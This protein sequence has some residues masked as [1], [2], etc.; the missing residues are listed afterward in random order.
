MERKSIGQF[1]AALRKTNGMTQKQLADLLAVSDKAISRWERDETAPDITLIPVLA[2]IFGVTSD[3]ILRG[4]RINNNNYNFEDNTGKAEK[5]L[6]NLLNTARTKFHIKNIISLGFAVVGLICAMIFNFGFNRARVGF[7]VGSIFFLVAILLEA[8]F[9]ISAFSASAGDDFESES[10]NDFKKAIIKSLRNTLSVIICVFAFTLPLIYLVNDAYVGIFPESW[11]GHGIICTAVGAVVCFL[12]W[13]I[14][15]QILVK[16]E[17]LIYSE[18]EKAKFKIQR[19]T[20]VALSIVL[21]A[22][23]VVQFVFNS[24][25]SYKNFTKGTVFT[26]ANEFIAYMEQ[27]KREYEDNIQASMNPIVT[28]TAPPTTIIDS[29]DVFYDSEQV[30]ESPVVTIPSTAVSEGEAVVYDSEDGTFHDAEEY[31]DDFYSEE[32]FVTIDGK[33]VTYKRRNFQVVSYNFKYDKSGNIISATTYTSK[34]LQQGNRIMDM[35]NIGFVVVYLLEIA[36]W[37]LKYFEKVKKLKTKP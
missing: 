36:F 6:K 19:K 8:I 12:G 31:I 11:F 15:K 3:E 17:V 23:F 21:A 27:P 18:D 24:A 16:K 4:E 30:T 32:D 26:D 9:L 1:I 13:W 22:T 2:E 37:V 35:I 20:L 28:A 29:E 5:R 10:I 25:F 34:D 33:E 7:F 14:T